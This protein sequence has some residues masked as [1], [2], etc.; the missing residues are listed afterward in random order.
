M[1]NGRS[2]RV[3]PKES[4]GILPAR[5]GHNFGQV[6][7]KLQRVSQTPGPAVAGPSSG[8]ASTNV[9]APSIGGPGPATGNS[10]HV[11]HHV[12]VHES[13]GN[14]QVLEN[15]APVA[16]VAPQSA[17]TFYPS[18]NPE[19]VH[20][21]GHAAN[22][23]GPAPVQPGPVPTFNHGPYAAPQ[24]NYYMP[25]PTSSAG[26]PSTAVQPQ[27][28]NGAD[29]YSSYYQYQASQQ[30]PYPGYYHMGYMPYTVPY[31]PVN[32]ATSSAMPAAQA[33]PSVEAQEF[34]NSSVGQGQ[35]THGPVVPQV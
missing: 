24:P 27:G 12:A 25:G 5:A 34:E 26:M 14:R 3:E 30:V 20:G 31:P 19:Y 23:A 10:R 28:N 16:Q 29:A 6:F 32:G 17:G 11:Q 35:E 4:V 21:H 9:P 18:G 8:P 33:G 15:P 22:M 1:F 7:A 13:N 2:I